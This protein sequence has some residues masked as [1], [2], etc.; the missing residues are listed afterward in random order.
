MKKERS[1]KFTSHFFR[2]R[3]VNS[4]GIGQSRKLSV[5]R[6]LLYRFRWKSSCVLTFRYSFSWE[7][8]KRENKNLKKSIFQKIL[9]I[10]ICK[11]EKIGKFLIPILRFFYNWRWKYIKNWLFPSI[12]SNFYRA[13]LEKPVIFDFVRFL[14]CPEDEIEKSGS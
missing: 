12:F 2:F 13:V 14:N 5:S 6:D 8:R 4:W 3:P 10:C 7:Y 11:V 9:L 1:K